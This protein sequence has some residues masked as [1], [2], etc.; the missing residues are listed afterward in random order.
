MFDVFISFAFNITE[1]FEDT[2][3]EGGDFGPVLRGVLTAGD[4]LE[5]LFGPLE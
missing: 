4:A 5:K 3:L 1:L 2:T